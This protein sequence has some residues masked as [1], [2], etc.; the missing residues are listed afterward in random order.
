MQ[1]EIFHKLM[2]LSVIISDLGL[3]KV[4][5]EE[6]HRLPEAIVRE[7][8]LFIALEDYAVEG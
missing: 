5:N 2:G 8:G 1:N 4:G 6:P 7:S 3:E